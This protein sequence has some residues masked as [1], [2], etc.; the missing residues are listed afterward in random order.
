M[1]ILMISTDR[2][3]FKEGS[4][5]R[6][7][8]L[9][10]G[11]LAERLDIIVFSLRK[12]GFKEESLGS[13][14]NLHPTNSLS[15]LFYIRDA[16]KIG[17]NMAGSDIITAQDPFETGLAGTRLARL[18][19]KP[20]QMQIHTDFLSPSFKGESL[21]NK[22]RVRMARKTLPQAAQIRVVSERIARS[23]ADIDPSFTAKTRILPI[24]VDANKI[25]GQTIK[26]DLH[27]KYPG[28]KFIILIASRFTPEKNIP[29]ALEALR[30]VVDHHPEVG[31]VLVGDGKE[32]AGLERSVR[33]KGLEK[34]VVFEEWQ[35]D[36]PSY[37]KTCDLFL[38]T[39]L[40]EG[41]GLTLVE[42]LVS[43]API[44]TTDVGIAREILGP[45]SERCICAENDAPCMEAAILRVV[46]NP[47]FAK[48]FREYSSAFVSDKL[49]STKESYLGSYRRLWLEL[50][51]EQK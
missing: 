46:E 41:Y 1:N 30:R 12:L 40:Y 14:V 28:F 16:V 29:L 2:N 45:F 18:L 35:S 13:N 37:Y 11:S 50:W 48:E 43:G 9:E 42:A 27:Q 7:R 21:L 44:V 24:F 32:K 49:N 23:L 5:V 34:H 20:L 3:V 6:E 4:A 25:K 17:K 38:S 36:L 8:M 15:R 51:S 39:S 22:I 26:I 19:H 33:E 10:Y 47:S 31:M